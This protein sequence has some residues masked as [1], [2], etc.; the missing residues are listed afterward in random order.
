M[1]SIGKVRNLNFV[2]FTPWTGDLAPNTGESTRRTRED[3]H[4]QKGQDSPEPPGVVHVEEAQE[5]QKSIKSRAEVL[6][7]FH[8]GR[9]LLDEGPNNGGQRQEDKERYT[10]SYR[11]KK[12]PK[13]GSSPRLPVSLFHFYLPTLWLKD[14]QLLEFFTILD[15]MVSREKERSFGLLGS[16]Q[17]P[18]AQIPLSHPNSNSKCQNS[19]VK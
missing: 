8:S 18:I 15:V 3:V 1:L 6:Y 17:R 7:I 19:N 16:S 12:V 13:G 9:I 10:Q 14:S 4:G 2:D 11:A 5:I